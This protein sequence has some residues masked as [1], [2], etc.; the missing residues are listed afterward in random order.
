VDNSISCDYIVLHNTL[1]ID[2]FGP[3]LSPSDLD[4]CSHHRIVGYAWKEIGRVAQEGAADVFLWHR[5][6]LVFFGIEGSKN[7]TCWGFVKKILEASL[8]DG[9]VKLRGS[10]NTLNRL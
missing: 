9:V 2:K 6:A 8:D 3:V 10:P 7:R 5:V 1:P 4:G